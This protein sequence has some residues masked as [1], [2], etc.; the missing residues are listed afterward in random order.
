MTLVHNERVGV[1]RTVFLLSSLVVL[2]NLKRS[3]LSAGGLAIPGHVVAESY[4]RC[5]DA[6]VHISILRLPVHPCYAMSCHA[7]ASML[8]QHS[9][10]P[11]CQRRERGEPS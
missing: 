8:L 11:P 10:R 2:H 4:N 6:V 3:K 7:I 1:V 5:P 9:P